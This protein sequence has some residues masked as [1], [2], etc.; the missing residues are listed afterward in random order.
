M[1][2]PRIKK[3]ENKVT[4][5]IVLALLINLLYYLIYVYPCDGPYSLLGHI[6]EGIACITIILVVMFIFSN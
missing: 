5:A 4:T 2:I 6:L 3:T 1:K